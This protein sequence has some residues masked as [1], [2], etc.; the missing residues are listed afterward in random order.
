MDEP[1]RFFA[2]GRGCDLY[3]TPAGAALAVARPADGNVGTELS[4]VSMQLRG[5]HRDVQ[6][7]G[8]GVLPGV[9]NYYLGNDPARWRTGVEG[10]ARLRYP[11][12]LPGVDVVYHG[13]DQ[14]HLEY[15]LVLAP[16]ANP[17][18]VALLFEGAESVRIDAGGQAVLRLP[19]GGD[20]VQTAPVAYQTDAKGRRQPVGVRYELRDG[21]LGFALG[22]FDRRR[23]LVIDPSIV[24]AT[25]LAGNGAES[26]GGVAVDPSGET[27]VVGFTNSTNFPLV[28]PAQGTF[29]GQ[30]LSQSNAFITKFTES[31]SALVYSTYLGGS[32]RSVGGGGDYA[33][34]VAVSSAG[35]AFVVGITGSTD[36]PTVAPLQA[37]NRNTSQDQTTT[38]VAK[39]T[40]SGALVYSTY[41]GGTFDDFGQAI[42]VDA[43]GEAF[44]AGEAGSIDFPTASPLQ[45]ASHGAADAFVAKLNASGSALVYSTYLG[46][47]AVDAANAIAVDPAGE[48]FV[49]GRTL[50]TD[51]PTASPFQPTN[52]DLPVTCTRC[53]VSRGDAFVTKL[54][55]A[56]SAMVYST[57]LGGGQG[58]GVA[59]LAIDPAGDAFVAGVTTSTDFPTASPYQPAPLAGPTAFVTKLDP[60]GAALLYS[61]YLDQ[62]SGYGIA[63]DRAGAALVV[64]DSLMAK[65]NPSGSA[66][67]YS[68]TVTGGQLVSVALN[69]GGQPSVV[70][71]ETTGGPTHVFFQKLADPTAVPAL[72]GAHLALAAFLLLATGWVARRQ[73]ELT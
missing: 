65:F 45:P 59:S 55:A 41:L 40:T 7:V 56:G 18:K 51:F 28:S 26:A 27:V 25:A 12:V 32:G 35:E 63:I 70:G 61:T 14:E 43:A 73:R 13:D 37:S 39:L 2:R 44:V 23:E 16:G 19:G 48:A 60:G 64:G 68:T 58:E 49:G 3:L 1:V 52:H 46:G 66:L 11:G 71:N 29:H 24:F 53:N 67:L 10:Y 4:F 5:G 34:G 33:T 57:Y 50:S 20:L 9:T 6:P 21:A 30:L 15:N 38:F 31:G 17:G 72:S 36:F 22:D 8:S 62:S 54:N 69:F 42:A 47:G